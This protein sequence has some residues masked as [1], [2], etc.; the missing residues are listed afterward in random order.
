MNLYYTFTKLAYAIYCE[1]FPS[2]H[3]SYTQFLLQNPSFLLRRR[4]RFAYILG[5]YDF[6]LYIL[7]SHIYM[8][9]SITMDNWIAPCWDSNA[10]K[11]E[12]PTQAR[13][14]SYPQLYKTIRS[15]TLNPKEVALISSQDLGS[16][17]L[18]IPQQDPK[19]KRI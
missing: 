11:R 9:P 19:K 7:K 13:M 15:L 2:S 4:N 1:L 17:V 10:H 14:F 5:G 18:N 8:L 6:N 3:R 12:F 16:V